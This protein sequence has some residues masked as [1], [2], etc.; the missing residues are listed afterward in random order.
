MNVRIMSPIPLRLTAQRRRRNTS[1][2]IT[3]PHGRDRYIR[4]WNGSDISDS[5]IPKDVPTGE[6]M[7]MGFRFSTIS[8]IIKLTG[9]PAGRSRVNWETL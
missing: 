2:L 8:T 4:T 9:F 6:K 1:D 3:S 7:P 5:D